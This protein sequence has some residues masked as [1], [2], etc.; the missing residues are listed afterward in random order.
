MELYHYNP[1]HDRLGKFAKSNTAVRR[2]LN[3]DRF[4]REMRLVELT[5][6]DTVPGYSFV[7]D[8]LKEST[9]E[10]MKILS[11]DFKNYQN[12]G[13]S[14]IR[15]ALSERAEKKSKSTTEENKSDSKLKIPKRKLKSEEKDKERARILRPEKEYDD[16]VRSHN[17]GRYEQVLPEFGSTER[18]V[19]AKYE[20]EVQ[21]IQKKK[22]KTKKWFRKR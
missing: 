4:K 16:L 9:K 22:R 2:T 13:K 21:K 20:P 7:K 1:N 8:I 5:V 15:D 14:F 10:T 12:D 17:T 6:A 18:P 11:D 19:D 3:A